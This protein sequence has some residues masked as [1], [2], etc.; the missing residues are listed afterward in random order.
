M[1]HAGKNM[2]ARMDLRKSALG[3]FRGNSKMARRL[4]AHQVICQPLET[5]RKLAKNA[6]KT[7][8]AKHRAKLRAVKNVA[9]SW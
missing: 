6:A 3:A 7:R 8:W 5:R 2:P 9:T 1:I 4:R